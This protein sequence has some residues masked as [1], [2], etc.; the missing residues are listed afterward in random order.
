MSQKSLSTIEGNMK[1][2][3]ARD[4]VCQRLES[5]QN[6]VSDR[7]QKPGTEDLFMNKGDL[8]NEVSVVTNSKKAYPSLS[9]VKL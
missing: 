8:I 4:N 3:T 5:L 2:F 9:R 1:I 7:T 6:K